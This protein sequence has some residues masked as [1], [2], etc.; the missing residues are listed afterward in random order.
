MGEF[1]ATTTVAGILSATDKTKLDN[2][3]GAGVVNS[4]VWFHLL[5]QP[6]SSGT[7]STA[8]ESGVSYVTKARF[9]FNFDRLNIA[10]TILGGKLYARGMV[11]AG[12]GDIRLFNVTD[13]V[14]FAVINFTESSFT[15]KSADLS[16]LPASGIKVCE[17]QMRK[18]AGAGTL[19][20][21]TASCDF[22]LTS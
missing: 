22:V 17:V 16:S 2:L 20:I 15:T 11:P 6:A 18:V 4:I 5:P 1:P 3:T 14:E 7:P 19:S 8:S 12:N 10:D 21:E 9:V 13:S